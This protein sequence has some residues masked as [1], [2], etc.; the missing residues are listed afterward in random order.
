MFQT[1]TYRTTAKPREPRRG[2]AAWWRGPECLVTLLWLLALSGT[3]AYG[4]TVANLTLTGSVQLTLNI[5]VTPRGAASNLD[6]T[7]TQPI[8]TVADITVTTNNPAG[9]GITVRSANI[10]NG[11]CGAPCFFS[12]TTT[13]N[14]G[15]TLYRSGVPL[16]FAG[17]TATFVQSTAPSGLG[18]A[19]YTADVSY[20]GAATLLGTATNYREILTFTVSVN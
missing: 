12:T 19:P 2:V 10:A 18:G 3:L 9:Y 5:G 6:L 17:D 1:D 14:L 8:L 11:D 20:D 16:T 7:I 15:F 4:A 13:E